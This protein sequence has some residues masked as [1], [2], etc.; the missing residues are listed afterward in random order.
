MS[1]GSKIKDVYARE[2]LSGRGHPS[3]E[4]TVITENGAIGV[5]E[6]TAGLSVGEHEVQFAYDGGERYHGLGVLKAVK[7][8]TDIIAPALKGVDAL[9]QYK[10]DERSSYER[11]KDY[12][13][14][15]LDRSD[16]S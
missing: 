16:R 3:I 4:A 7:N 2:I 12:R 14:H 1:N 8:V 5:A 13:R 10:V 11:S 9:K 6:A 15:Q